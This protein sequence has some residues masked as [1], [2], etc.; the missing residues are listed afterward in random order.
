MI[1]R[2]GQYK[3]FL[4][5]GTAL[6][7]QALV[8]VSQVQVG[9]SLWLIGTVLATCGLSIGLAQQSPVIGV[10][11][12]ASQGDIGA[13]TGAVTLCRMAE[14][15]VISQIPPV[16]RPMSSPRYLRPAALR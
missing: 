15:S 4:I 11:L 6:S 7:V 5:T 8:G 13:A 14:M 3:P 12:V 9:T 2:T 1:E 16:C 10:Q